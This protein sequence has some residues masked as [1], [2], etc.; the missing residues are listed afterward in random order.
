MPP[1]NQK[2]FYAIFLVLAA[3]AGVFAMDRAVVPYAS[4]IA[5]ISVVAIAMS[6]GAGGLSVP[7]GLRDAI[8]RAGSGRRP[9]PPAGASPDV[10]ELY[11]AL[12]R[13]AD[14]IEDTHAHGKR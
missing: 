6:G 2:Q 4:A 5:V 13:V 8:D 9:E 14:T 3:L 12:S 10:A 11:A 7:A 1:L